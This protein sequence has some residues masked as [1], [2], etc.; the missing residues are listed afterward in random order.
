M[1]QTST[2]GQWPVQ[3]GAIQEFQTSKTSHNSERTVTESAQ[4]HTEKGRE[5]QGK[6]EALQQQ[7]EET[8]KA[9]DVDFHKLKFN[10]HDTLDQIFVQVLNRDTDE[11]IREIPPEKLLDMKAALLKISGVIVDEEV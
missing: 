4:K 3:R 1:I 9:L 10:V 8:N 11:V 2:E 7:G 6:R 5:A